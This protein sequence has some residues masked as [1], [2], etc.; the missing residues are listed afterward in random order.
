M[1]TKVLWAFFCR[2]VYLL[3]VG[4]WRG[5]RAETFWLR[6]QVN[7]IRCVGPNPAGRCAPDIVTKTFYP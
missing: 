6:G 1:N 3:C 5:E 4:V 7:F 2:W